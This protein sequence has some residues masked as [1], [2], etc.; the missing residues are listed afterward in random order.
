[1]IDDSDQLQSKKD[2]INNLDL[3]MIADAMAR[4]LKWLPS[5]VNETCRYYKNFLFLKYKYPKEMI[6][7]STDVDEVWHNH[8]LDTKKYKVDC[9][10]IF[11]KYLDHYPY[12]GMDAHSTREDLSNAFKRTQELHIQEFNYPIK[13][14]TYTGFSRLIRRFLGD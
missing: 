12:F 1:M 3:S 10:N 11:G 8:I 14:T 13:S 2:Q 7:P 9:K 4:R 6:V 5:E